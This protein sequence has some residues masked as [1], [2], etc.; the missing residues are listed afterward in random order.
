MAVG[1]A[2]GRMLT[3][4]EAAD[5]LG[6]AVITI[7]LWVARR[8]IEHVKLGRS[9]RIPEAAIDALVARSTVPPLRQSA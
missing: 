5:R 4:A 3:C 6:L 1:S 9:V 7:R 2:R 8:K